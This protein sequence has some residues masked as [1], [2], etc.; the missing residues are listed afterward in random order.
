MKERERV[1]GGG[2]FKTDIT[3][4]KSIQWSS[5]A[6]NKGNITKSQLSKSQ[7]PPSA[8]AFEDCKYRES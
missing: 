1:T 4:L 8:A 3:A 2:P 5:E 7:A 6:E